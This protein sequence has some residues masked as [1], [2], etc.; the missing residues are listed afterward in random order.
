MRFRSLLLTSALLLS[1]SLVLAKPTVGSVSY[2]SN[3]VAGSPITLSASVSSN[4]SLQSCNL[5]LDSEDLGA[6]SINGNTA[7]LDH[8]F[9]F[10]GVYTAFVFCR[11]VSNGITSGQNTSIYIPNGPTRSTEPYNG[12]SS[13]GST[14]TPV[15]VIPPTPTPVPTMSAPLAGLTFGTLLKTACP[16]NGNVAPDHPCKAVYY[17]GK[18]GKRHAFPN[19]KVYFTWYSNFD[20]VAT[21]TPEVMGS[22]LLGK[23][24]TYRPGVR[25]VKFTTLNNV[26]AVSK[27]GVLRWVTTEAVAVGLYGA[28]WN[29]KIDDVPD[30]VYTNYT[31]GAE[32]KEVSD[33]NLS[34]EM[35]STVKVDD[36]L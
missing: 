21:V 34:S 9:Q 31:F 17:Y 12:G 24:V 29:K 19:D 25:M 16:E 27:G 13:G 10:A 7:S 4:V 14:P 11:D 36:T 2:P 30:T 26:Y 3:S 32:I 35:S 6:M 1:P 28:D 18:D 15:P 5:Y 23:N 20:S 22:M 8:N 33:Y